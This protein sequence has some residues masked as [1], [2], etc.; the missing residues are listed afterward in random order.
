MTL[1]ISYSKQQPAIG[2]RVKLVRIPGSKYYTDTELVPGN[3]GTIFDFSY[4]PE[5]LGGNRQIWVKWDSGLELALI[6]G[7][8]SFVVLD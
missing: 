7:E 5:Q 6:E 8:D 3:Q 1:H 4:L 2:K